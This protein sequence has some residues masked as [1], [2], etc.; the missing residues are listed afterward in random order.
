MS[1]LN[2]YNTIY[3]NEDEDESNSSDVLSREDTWQAFTGFSWSFIVCVQN[4][5][6]ILHDGDKERG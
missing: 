2:T 1:Q 6:A 3:Y 5:W 4:L